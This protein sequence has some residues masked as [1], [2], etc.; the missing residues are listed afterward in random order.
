MKAGLVILYFAAV[1]LVLLWRFG[2]APSDGLEQ[3]VKDEQRFNALESTVSRP[4]SAVDNQSYDCGSFCRFKLEDYGSGVLLLSTPGV[5]LTPAIQVK[6]NDRIV[7]VLRSGQPL[8]SADGGALKLISRVSPDGL[9]RR[10]PRRLF[11]TFDR[12]EYGSGIGHRFLRKNQREFL[13]N[14]CVVL[15]L[16]KFIIQPAGP[17]PKLVF[18]TRPTDCV[19]FRTVVPRILVE[20]TWTSHDLLELQLVEPNGFKFKPDNPDGNPETEGRYSIDTWTSCDSDTVR[21]NRMSVWY[22]RRANADRGTYKVKIREVGG[23]G[24]PPTVFRVRV[25][26]GGKL[27]LLK[28]GETV[29]RNPKNRLLNVFTFKYN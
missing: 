4:L 29:A 25:Y 2:A 20:L 9:L 19:Q 10:F 17:Q 1:A 14:L 13:D 23:C 27:V 16:R 15:P 8:V 6:K 12:T 21:E 3:E 7:H 5:P 24:D 22:P 28:L 11:K 18:S 26:I